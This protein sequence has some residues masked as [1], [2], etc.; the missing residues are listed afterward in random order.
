MLRHNARHFRDKL[1][2]ASIA[3]VLRAPLTVGQPR[4]GTGAKASSGR[5]DHPNLPDQI[6]SPRG[7]GLPAAAWGQPEAPKARTSAV[8]TAATREPLYRLPPTSSNRCC[9]AVKFARVTETPVSLRSGRSWK[10]RV[11]ILGPGPAITCRPEC[12]EAEFH[13]RRCHPCR[14]ASAQ[15]TPRPAIGTARAKDPAR[16]LPGC[17]PRICG[18]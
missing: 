9:G 18:S 10:F 5:S 1:L 13:H 11:V 4:N 12:G 8:R 2:R 15:L 3:C 16:Q 14:W 7:L 6:E 17:R